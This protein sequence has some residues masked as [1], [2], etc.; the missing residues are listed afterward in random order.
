MR[1]L[2]VTDHYGASS[3]SSLADEA[4]ELA[5]LG[6]DVCIFATADTDRDAR[7]DGRDLGSGTMRVLAPRALPWGRA[8]VLTGALASA[9]IRHPVRLSRLL[10]AARR[11]SA[12]RR[13]FFNTLYL[14][15]PLLARPADIVHFAWIDLAKMC[16]DVLPLLASPV[17]VSC[18][19]SDLLVNP[20]SDEKFH[21][22]IQAVFQRADLVRCFSE[23]LRD[24]ALDL[25]LNPSK[26]LVSHWGVD[27]SFFCPAPGRGGVA[28]LRHASSPVRAPCGWSVSDTCTG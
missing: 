12:S 25:G 19:G 26:A 4:L 11:S 24:H 6:N 9:A 28:T 18:T 23:D 10:R 5:A 3:S 17:V 20:L 2:L 21:E 15:V 7:I 13:K 22:L 8:L 14:S 16:I 1:I 27:T